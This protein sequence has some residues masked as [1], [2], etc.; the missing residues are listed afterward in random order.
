ML[1]AG[2]EQM[3]L[4]NFE[5]AVQLYGKAIELNPANAVYFCNRYQ[6]AWEEHTVQPRAGTRWCGLCMR[7]CGSS[8][9][10]WPPSRTLGSAVLGAASVRLLLFSFRCLCHLRQGFPQPYTPV[11][12]CAGFGA[13]MVPVQWVQCPPSTQTNSDACVGSPAPC[14][15]SV[16]DLMSPAD[17]FLSLPRA[18]AYSKLGNYVG[19]VQDCERA[20][21]IDP[22][23]SKAYGR[24]G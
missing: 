20:I 8:P 7:S 16:E 9:S 3:R 4:E 24:M 11:K 10:V 15:A 1:P 5:A 6:S 18:A 21:S 22:G 2:N 12:A 17:C 14:Q 23:Y 19:A 13:S